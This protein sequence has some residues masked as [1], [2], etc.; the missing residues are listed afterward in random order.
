MSIDFEIWI[1]KRTKLEL[2]NE[3]NWTEN[4]TE[5]ELKTEP[6]LNPYI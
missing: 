6:K 1:K 3:P 2:K 4:R 5:I